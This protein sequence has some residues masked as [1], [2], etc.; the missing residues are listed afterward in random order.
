MPTTI[1][2][3]VSSAMS[4]RLTP[5]SA[6]LSAAT[7]RARR[8]TLISSCSPAAT[9]PPA[10]AKVTLTSPGVATF[11]TGDAPSSSSPSS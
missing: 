1:G 7:L 9:V 2:V 3:P 8:L 11:T 6:T 10:L 4:C 5:I